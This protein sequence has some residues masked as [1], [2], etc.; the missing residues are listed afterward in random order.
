MIK[1][2]VEVR[3]ERKGLERLRKAFEKYKGTTV[4]VGLFGGG[5]REEQEI[6]AGSERAL[7]N[8]EIGVIH[9]FGSSDGRIPERSFIRATFAAKRAEY[10]ALF[11][12]FAEK[13][14]KGPINWRQAFELVGMRVTADMKNRITSGDGIPPPLAPSTV[15]RKGSDR[16]LVD[17]GQLVNAITYVVERK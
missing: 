8:L 11:R 14:F 10:Q 3:A 15:A 17:T 6:G 1:P 4:K 16:P 5:T 12:R 9:E 13:G 2:S 7:S